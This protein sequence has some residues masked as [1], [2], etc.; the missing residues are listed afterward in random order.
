M[1][2]VSVPFFLAG[3]TFRIC[4]W[5]RAPRS[6]MKLGVFGQKEDGT[7]RWLKLGKDSFLFPQ[8]LDIDRRMWGFVICFHLAGVALFIGHLRLIF[9]FTPLANALGDRGMEQ[10]AF[11][12]GG[13]IGI[14]L[15]ITVLYF[16]IRRLTL[17]GKNISLPEDYFLLILLLLVIFTG[18]Y[19]RFFVDVPVTAYRQYVN[20]LF[21]F[22]PY[23]PTALDTTTTRW[24]L[25]IHV[26]FANILIFYLPFTKVTHFVGTFATN[27]IR[28]EYLWMNSYR[29][30]Y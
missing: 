24:S 10:F 8:V 11:L 22:N 27:L 12:T 28:R 9:E 16:L 6:E 3:M 13:T 30:P 23:I 15:L 21:S 26:M 2:W 19:M 4:Q 20:S 14:I 5:F 7:A 25:G 18:A 29:R 1:V 17:P